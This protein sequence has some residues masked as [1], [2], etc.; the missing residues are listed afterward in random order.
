[1]NL[2]VK[3][4]LDAGVHFGHQLR[5]FNPRSKKYV[6]DHRHGISVINLEKTYVCLERATEYVEHLAAQGKKILFVGTKKQAQEIV[7]EAATAC[8]MPFAANRWMGGGLT[9]FTTI[10]ASLK[11]YRGYLEMEADGRLAKHHKKEA[12][13]IRRTMNRMHRNFE[14][15]LELEDLPDALFI[16][17]TNH[18]DIAVA[19]AN[20]LHIPIIGV[21]DTNADP[22]VVQ[23]PIPANDDSLKS[24]RVIV[25]TIMEAIQSGNAQ[26]EANAQQGGRGGQRFGVSAEEEIV[27][28]T[29]SADPEDVEA[30]ASDPAEVLEEPAPEPVAEEAPAEEEVPTEEPKQ[31]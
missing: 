24:I 1:M 10:K 16:V 31:S 28:E 6:F 5:R 13:A 12:A 29:F 20:R 30:L 19:E 25:E 22:T 8:G 26:R 14:G 9:N 27:P 18:E 2:T 15:M 3:D 4:L 23:Y 21:V 17:D 11:K 7:R